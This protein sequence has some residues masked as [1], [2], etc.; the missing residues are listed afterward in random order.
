VL[1]V[2]SAHPIAVMST[3]RGRTSINGFVP[4][5]PPNPPSIE[6]LAAMVER[7]KQRDPQVENKELIQFR[8]ERTPP[9]TIQPQRLRVD[10]IVPT[11]PQRLPAGP[12]DDQGLVQPPTPPAT[13]HPDH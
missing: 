13:V 9:A 7:L 11:G 3:E 1:V 5:S 10:P 8:G 4:S 6:E 2:D 12:A